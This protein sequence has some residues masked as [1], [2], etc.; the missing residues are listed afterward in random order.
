MDKGKLSQKQVYFISTYYIFGTMFITL[1]RTLTE[2]ALHTGWLCIFLA[3][4]LF[5]GYSYLVSKI[6]LDIKK[7]EFIPY[8]HSF[9]GKWVGPPV[10]MLLL[11]L[12]TLF[13]SA[14]VIRLV[15]ELFATLILPETPVEVMI[16]MFLVLRYWTLQGGIR[17]VG[18]LAEML[19]PALTLVLLSMLGMSALH[20]QMSSLMPFFDTDLNGTFKGTVAVLSNFME[21]GVLL[22][23]AGRIR[24]PQNS[25][26]SMLWVNITVGLLFL[27][28]Y[29]ICLGNFG[30]AYTKRLAFPTIEMVRNI[31]LANFIEHVE[32]V[33]F[34]MWV[35][36]NVVK[37]SMTFYACCVGFQSWFGLNSYKPLML[38]LLILVYYL[39]DIP[40]NV[41]QSVF[42]FEQFK[43][44]VY[45]Y[46]GFAFVLLLY[47]LG[48]LRNKKKGSGP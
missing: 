8:M 41:L 34:A 37:G 20:T 10:T 9:L 32:I 38:P 47:G 30:T 26:K 44:S 1:P 18:M 7:Q 16:I 3:M 46:Y 36:M 28:T 45:P 42:R 21:I 25:L 6:I 24:N 43:T 22:F 13:Y 19:L 14:Y 2:V 5:A 29:W 39:S 35:M 31:S 48:R 23:V 4:I 12:P 40:Q 15:T 11:L 33:F 17:A 27:A